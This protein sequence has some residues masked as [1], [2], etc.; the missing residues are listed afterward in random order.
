MKRSRII[1]HFIKKNRSS[2]RKKQTKKNKQ[3]RKNKSMKK[4]V[5]QKSKLTRNKT[6]RKQYKMKNMKGGG[7]FFSQISHLS[8]SAFMPLTNNITSPVNPDPSIQLPHYQQVTSQNH[9]HLMIET[10]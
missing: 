2:S 10:N 4:K 8:Q 5:F 7:N 9:P 3:T 6:K 1:N